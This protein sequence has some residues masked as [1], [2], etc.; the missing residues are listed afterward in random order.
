LRDFL[1]AVV[2]KEERRCASCY[3]MRLDKTAQ[4]AHEKGHRGFSTTLLYSTYQNHP[5]IKAQAKIASESHQVPFVYQ[6]FRTGWQQGID[7]AKNLC[8]YR[9]SYCGCIYSEQE[10]YDNRLKKKLKKEKINDVQ[11]SRS[12]HHQPK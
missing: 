7:E 6:D 11:P 10:R 4:L 5:Q 3:L 12:G 9:Q 2:F 8:L 1:R